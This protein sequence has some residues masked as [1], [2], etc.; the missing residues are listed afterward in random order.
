M[1]SPVSA[2]QRRPSVGV[3]LKCCN[4]YVRAHLNARH[5]AYVGWCPRC[6]A[7]VRIEISADGSRSRFFEAS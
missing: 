6:A 2:T 3:L 1:E 4:V 5:D 7:P